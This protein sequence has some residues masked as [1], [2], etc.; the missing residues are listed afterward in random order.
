MFEYQKSD[1]IRYK[2]VEKRFQICEDAICKILFSG[3][4]YLWKLESINKR[5]NQRRNESS[6]LQASS[7][8]EGNG[9]NARKTSPARVVC[10][11]P[12]FGRC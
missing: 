4:I 2:K 1:E 5:V 6:N 3:M 10:R 8:Q 12:S 7:T 11:P 9:I